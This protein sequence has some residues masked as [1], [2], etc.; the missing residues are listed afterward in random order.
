MNNPEK[1]QLK[2]TQTV[3]GITEAELQKISDLLQGLLFGSV[4]IT[5]QDGVIVQIER[6]EKHRLR[7]P[8]QNFSGG[9]AR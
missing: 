2:P 8:K 6:T 5:V 3:P 7:S 4:A 9:S 1:K